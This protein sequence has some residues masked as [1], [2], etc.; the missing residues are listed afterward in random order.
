MGFELDKLEN[1]DDTYVCLNNTTGKVFSFYSIPQLAE[2]IAKQCD[3]PFC[4]C[5]EYEDILE[6]IN[7][8]WLWS[9][10]YEED[11]IKLKKIYKIPFTDA[12]LEHYQDIFPKEYYEKLFGEEK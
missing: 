6:Y 8:N 5:F 4:E 2:E 1:N 7:C 9:D 3:K 10:S 11:Q 12:E